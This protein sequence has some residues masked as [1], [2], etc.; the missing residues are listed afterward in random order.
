MTK[1]NHHLGRFDLTG[2]KKAPRGVPQIQVTFQIDVNGILKVTAT[3]KDTG[4][5]NKIA[6]DKS[7]TSLSPEEVERMIK[8]AEE[9]AEEDKK[10]KERIDAKSSLE[11]LAYATRKQISDLDEGIV[12]QKISE[13][14]AAA[15]T[16]ACDKTLTW[17][18]NNPEASLEE[19]SDAKSEL[20]SVLHPIM[21]KLYQSTDNTAQ[22]SGEREE[23]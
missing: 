17:L 14:E 16:K 1:D 20:E 19:F 11:G 3:D 4:R 22:D 6:I 13:E 9:F 2:L 15:V 12:G 8:E 18:E 23:L 5:E 7:D 21:S 10:V